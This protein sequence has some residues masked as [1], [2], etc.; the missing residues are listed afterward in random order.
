M[1]ETNTS[2]ALQISHMQDFSQALGRTW[3]KCL[4]NPMVALQIAMHVRSAWTN[5]NMMEMDF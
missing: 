3:P 2:V 1:F 4:H 5:S